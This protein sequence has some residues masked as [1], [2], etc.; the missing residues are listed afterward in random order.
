MMRV[1]VL[2][3][4]DTAARGERTD[5][6]GPSIVSWVETHGGTVVDH[7][8]VPD[9][10]V[11]IVQALLHWCDGARADVV[12]TTGGTGLTSR[13]VTPEA[14]RVV[15]EREAPALTERIRVLDVERFPRAALSR[16]I[17]GARHRTLIVTLPGS[18]GGVRDGL[19]ALEPI[20]SHA[21]AHVR[22]EPVDHERM[23][24]TR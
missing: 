24:G 4:S 15:I 3:V 19:T 18:P 5:V 14:A 9:D 23:S 12:F 10:T 7:R 17:A 1:A 13:D 20:L 21:I 8:V 11:R 22:D 2:T 16:G 6:S